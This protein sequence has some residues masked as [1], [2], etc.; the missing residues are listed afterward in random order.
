MEIRAIQIKQTKQVKPVPHSSV[1]LVTSHK[2]KMD[3]Q[4]LPS[5][6]PSSCD[7]FSPTLLLYLRLKE[8]ET[9]QALQII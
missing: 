3:F 8:K 7:T 9:P 4:C 6:Y 5:A 1:F 2:E